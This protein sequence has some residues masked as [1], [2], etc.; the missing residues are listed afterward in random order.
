MMRV[1][2][3]DITQDFREPQPMR[4]MIMKV[5]RVDTNIVNHHQWPVDLAV[6]VILVMIMV[7]SA[8]DVVAVV[9]A[10]VVADLAES[11]VIVLVH[12]DVI[13]VVMVQVHL[14]PASVVHL[15]VKIDHHANLLTII[16][17]LSQASGGAHNAD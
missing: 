16:A 13:L 3:M 1:K 12:Q 17:S 5:V 10:E 11:M 14:V 6:A 2:A 15:V 9:V 4:E 8:A 7:A